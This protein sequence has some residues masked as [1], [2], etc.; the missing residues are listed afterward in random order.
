M[1]RIAANQGMDA[2][3]LVIPSNLR[4]KLDI[5]EGDI[6]EML[7]INPEEIILKKYNNS[8]I[9]GVAT[10]VDE[11][12]RVFISIGLRRELGINGYGGVDIYVDQEVIV[13]KRHKE[14][15]VIC[16]NVAEDQTSRIFPR[17]GLRAHMSCLVAAVVN[18]LK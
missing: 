1:V 12:G 5:K 7:T 4:K 15:C 6:L 14:L 2:G 3:R 11:L 13:L 16:G 8:K 18:E 10:K 9:M 17:T